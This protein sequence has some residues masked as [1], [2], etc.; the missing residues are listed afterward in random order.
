MKNIFFL[1]GLLV[2]S[3]GLSGCAQNVSPNTYTTS[4]V[5][6]ASK[7]VAGTIIAKRTIIIDN[8]TGAGG[9]AGVAAGAAAGSAVGGS[10]ASGVVGAVGGAVLGGVIGN[11]IDKSINKKQG[12][13]YIIKLTN[14]STI[15]VT[16]LQDMQFAIG[17]HVLVIYG[18]LT[19]I[20]PD[21][22]A[23]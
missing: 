11:V 4:E 6:V 20:I 19:R 16:Q 14:G 12:F 2:I 3:F 21:E 18:A 5:G 10:A 7:V 22:S 8:N 15:S 23:K 1:A 17:Q 13:E 9:L